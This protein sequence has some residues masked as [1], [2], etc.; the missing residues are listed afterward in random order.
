MIG[1]LLLLLLLLVLVLVLVLIVELS[2]AGTKAS[3]DRVSFFGRDLSMR[4]KNL[5]SAAVFR[6]LLLCSGTWPAALW[7]RFA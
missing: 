5:A 2:N 6:S 4:A 7:Q 3:I 1:S